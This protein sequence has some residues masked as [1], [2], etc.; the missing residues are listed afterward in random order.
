MDRVEF[1]ENDFTRMIERTREHNISGQGGVASATPLP[2]VQ[3]AVL[4]RAVVEAPPLSPEERERLDAEARKLGIMPGSEADEK[5][6]YETL[7]EAIAAGAPVKSQDIPDR[8]TAREFLGRSNHPR[9]PDFRNVQSIDL[10]NGFVVVDGLSFKMDSADVKSYRR[11]AVEVARQALT[12]AMD[13]AL[14]VWDAEGEDGQEPGVE[15]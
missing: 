11:Y 14:K 6:Q 7:E 4:G 9:I 8:M 1:P 3:S 15:A 13:E 2:T 5:P 12:Q 10:V